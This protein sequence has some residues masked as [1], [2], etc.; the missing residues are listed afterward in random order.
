MSDTSRYPAQVFWSEEDGGYIALAPDLPGCSAFGVTQDEALTE[1]REAAKAWIAAQSAAGNPIPAPSELPVP[2]ES[3]GRILLRMPKS[4][5]AKL[6][7]DAKAEGVS[8]NQY[9]LYRLAEGRS[10][11]P[12]PDFTPVIA[13]IEDAHLRLSNL[14]RGSMVGGLGG[15]AGQLELLGHSESE[16]RG[17]PMGESVTDSSGAK[18]LIVTSD[19]NYKRLV[20]S[21]FGSSAHGGLL[22]FVPGHRYRIADEVENG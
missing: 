9:I 17:W 16:M 19:V 2:A 7:A 6:V 14:G 18:F 12:A 5:H 11:T 10:K 8:L 15:G 4:L 1:L 20:G 22:N 13:A 3:S 21:P